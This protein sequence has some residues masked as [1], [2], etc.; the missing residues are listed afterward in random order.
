MNQYREFTSRYFYLVRTATGELVQATYSLTLH[1][2][3]DIGQG[4]REG[5]VDNAYAAQRT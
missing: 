1:R 5:S 3:H 2:S 4:V